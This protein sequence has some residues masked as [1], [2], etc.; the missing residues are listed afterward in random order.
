MAFS[1][2]SSFAIPKPI[3]PFWDGVTESW[4][5]VLEAWDASSFTNPR[6]GG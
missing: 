2:K 1:M 5:M 6:E 4:L 3:D